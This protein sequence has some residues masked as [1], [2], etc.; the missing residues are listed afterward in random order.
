MT[1]YVVNGI[2]FLCFGSLHKEQ[3][4]NWE[5]CCYSVLFWPFFGSWVCLYSYWFVCEQSD[6]S[7]LAQS[8]VLPPITATH[9]LSYTFTH[10]VGTHTVEN[11]RK[12]QSNTTK[13]QFVVKYWT[14]HKLKTLIP[15]NA[16]E[17]FQNHIIDYG[18]QF[19]SFLIGAV[20]VSNKESV[21]YCCSCFPLTWVAPDQNFQSCLIILLNKQW[22]QF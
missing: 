8:V 1:A 10:A 12:C 18:L 20:R 5:L 2:N 4:L 11:A 21:I 14:S 22:P 13:Y 3:M 15:A 6:Q 9:C 16:T 19:L 7:I 17:V